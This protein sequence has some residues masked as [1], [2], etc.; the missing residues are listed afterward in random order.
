[1][2]K[3]GAKMVFLLCLLV[4]NMSAD[5]SADRF[6]S[7]ESDNAVQDLCWIGGDISFEKAH[8]PEHFGHFRFP[9]PVPNWQFWIKV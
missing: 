6:N 8:K 7:E 1:M 3:L 5:K 2:F 9:I 4:K